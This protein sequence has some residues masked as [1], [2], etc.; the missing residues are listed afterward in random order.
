MLLQ[1][2]RLQ[3]HLKNQQQQMLLQLLLLVML[4]LVMV[5]MGWIV[6]ML[7]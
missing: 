5:G 7:S 4:L 2:L 1:Q 6:W 3:T